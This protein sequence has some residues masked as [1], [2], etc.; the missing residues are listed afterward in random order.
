MIEKDSLKTNRYSRGVFFNIYSER[1]NE[2]NYKT[3]VSINGLKSNSKEFKSEKIIINDFPI[4]IY[5]SVSKERSLPGVF[6]VPD[7][8]VWNFL[9][10]FSQNE[11][12]LNELNPIYEMHKGEFEEQE[13]TDF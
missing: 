10:E 13:D 1:I 5:Y 4:I 6:F 8:K 2:F 7:C 9:S 3:Y 12:Y 11:I